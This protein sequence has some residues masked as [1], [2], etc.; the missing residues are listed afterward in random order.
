MCTEPLECNGS[1]DT[2]V[3]R[4][5]TPYRHVTPDAVLHGEG[6]FV[7]ALPAQPRAERCTSQLNQIPMWH[8]DAAKVGRCYQRKS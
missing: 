2:E 8:S 6:P 7:A 1:Q 3:R 5:F 4:P